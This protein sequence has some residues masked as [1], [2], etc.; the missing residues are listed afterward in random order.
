M[1]L[2][3]RVESCWVHFHTLAGF[4]GNFST[5]IFPGK[6]AESSRNFSDSTYMGKFGL[7][8]LIFGAM[9]TEFD[10]EPDSGL[11]FPTDPYFM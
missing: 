6:G 10:G 2:S 4:T 1:S 8:E 7:Q 11:R 5:Y 3:P 9:V